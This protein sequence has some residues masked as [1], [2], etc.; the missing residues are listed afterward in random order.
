MLVAYYAILAFPLAV[1]VPYS[2]FRSLAAEQED[3]TYE[4]LSITTLTS[5]QIITGKLL[6]AIVQMMV[7]LS[8]VSPCLA[9]TF[10][11]RGIDMPT[12]AMLLAIA[13][14]GSLG[15]SMLGLFVGAASRAKHT[16]IV[17]SVAL[18]IGLFSAFWGRIGHGDGGERQ[19]LSARAGVL[20]VDVRDLRRVCDH[21]RP[22]SRGG[23]GSDCLPQRESLHA[24]ASVDD[25][26]TGLLRRRNCRD[27]V[28]VRCRLAGGAPRRGTVRHGRRVGVLVRH[29]GADDSR[30][31][32]P[33]AAG[34]RS[35]PQ[36]TLGRA[37]LSF[38][39][40]GPGAGYI[41][42]VS[43]L[44]AVL[45][46]SL[47]AAWLTR[48]A[49]VGSLGFEKVFFFIVLCWGYVVAYL[50]LGRLRDCDAAAVD[51]RFADRWLSVATW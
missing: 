16:Q 29:G 22:A 7:Y 9:F 30:V 39:N 45:A 38:F 15:L 28:R 23:D 19:W 41:F 49:I 21:L 50:G 13:V 10:L 33:L 35:L 27:H 8:A 26:A 46:A 51:V 12:T 44:T 24:V 40:P 37:F 43:N 11:L 2:A 34:A 18:V 31:A 6:S 1:I 32:A 47:A 42:A 20:G 4:L 5:R 17:T 48:N 14:L 36:S 25:G 3:N